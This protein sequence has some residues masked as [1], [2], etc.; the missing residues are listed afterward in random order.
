MTDPAGLDALLKDAPS[1]I[2]GMVAYIQNLLL[3]VHWAPAYRMRLSDAR[4]EEAHT[5]SVARDAG[6]DAA[7]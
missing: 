1:D 6:A 5:R 7:S 4:Q 3:H 2:P